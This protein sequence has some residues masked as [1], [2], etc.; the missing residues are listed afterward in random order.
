MVTY[1][2][3]Q[4]GGDVSWVGPAIRALVFTLGGAALIAVGLRRRRNLALWEQEQD[5]RA[6]RKG[7]STQS[8]SRSPA[9]PPRGSGIWFIIFGALTV[10]LGFLHVFDLFA[11]LIRSGVI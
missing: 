8:D 10:I 1:V 5:E 2:L 3:A 7:R 11:T 9:N 6:L 4:G